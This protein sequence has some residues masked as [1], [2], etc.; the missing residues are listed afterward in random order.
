MRH[1][2]E[3]QIRLDALILVLRSVTHSKIEG[4][5]D[6]LQWVLEENEVMEKQ[7]K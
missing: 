1:E 2:D 5:K 3:V 6:A 7:P 4:W